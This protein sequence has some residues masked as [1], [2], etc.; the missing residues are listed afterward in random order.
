[1]ITYGMFENNNGLVTYTKIPIFTMDLLNHQAILLN[2]M[3]PVT[4]NILQL[5][6]YSKAR[7]WFP[8]E[9]YDF[10]IPTTVLLS[11]EEEN[12]NKYNKN[13]SKPNDEWITPPNLSKVQFT[14]NKILIESIKLKKL[15]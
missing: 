3:V 5:T 2:M 14:K 6:L 10:L 13:K 1:M 7:P 15:L 9:P 11:K 8:L 12:I 4:L